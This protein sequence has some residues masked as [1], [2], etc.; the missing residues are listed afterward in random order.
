LRVPG[1]W[2][3]FEVMVRAVIGQQISVAGARTIAGTLTERFGA[4]VATGVPGLTHLFP[5]PAALAA[6]D[7]ASLPMPRARGRT[8]IALARAVADGGRDLASLGVAGIGPWTEAYVAL[9][10]GD[11]DAFPASDL[12]LRR[13]LDG[14][15]ARE[16][17][18]WA[19]PLRPFRA[20]A[21]LHL[22]CE[23]TT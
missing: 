12:G 23:E 16:V 5:A 18:A 8:L 20:Y 2:D 17:E 14:R 21:A 3:P 15:P 6:V 9:R 11:P 19:E 1:A 13:A 7:P 22:W 4:P 10:L